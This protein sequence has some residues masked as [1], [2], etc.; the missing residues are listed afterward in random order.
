MADARPDEPPRM[1]LSDWRSDGADLDMSAIFYRIISYK[2]L[3][4]FTVGGYS[5]PPGPEK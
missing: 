1:N 3:Q 5:S 2:L 4:Q